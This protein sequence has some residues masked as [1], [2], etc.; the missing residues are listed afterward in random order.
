VIKFVAGGKAK[1][2]KLSPP[3]DCGFKISHCAKHLASPSHTHTHTHTHRLQSLFPTQ[4]L[5]LS[6][7]TSRDEDEDYNETSKRFPNYSFFIWPL[8]PSFAATFV[9]LLLLLLLLKL[10]EP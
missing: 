8:I 2:A 5:L 4:L 6:A 7:T 10:Y 1:R 9:G 3:M